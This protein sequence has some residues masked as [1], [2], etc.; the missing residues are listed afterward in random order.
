M[1]DTMDS[2]AKMNRRILVIDD[3]EAIHA[4]F[5]KILMPAPVASD[6]LLSAEADLFG[7]PTPALDRVAFEVTNASQ[8]EQGYRL[9]KAAA[10]AGLPF[11]MAFVDMRM[12]LGWDGLETIQRIWAEFPDIEMVIC[13]AFSDYS[14]EE[15]IN[16][17]GRT[18]RLLIVKKPF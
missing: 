15:T 5:Q 7:E 14:W 8:G 9:V 17:L 2:K 11:A 13:T 3:N 16:K 4:D 18:D 1:T 10:A 6:D 12:P